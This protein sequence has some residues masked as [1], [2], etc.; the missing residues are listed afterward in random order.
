MAKNFNHRYKS[1]VN[2][3]DRKRSIVINFGSSDDLST[4]TD[5]SLAQQNLIVDKIPQVK[6]KLQTTYV[7]LTKAITEFND[8]TFPAFIEKRNTSS[9]RPEDIKKHRESLKKATKE[10][11]DSLDK[12]GSLLI[13]N[14]KLAKKINKHEQS[15]IFLA[16]FD[17][18]ILFGER[19]HTARDMIS[20]TTNRLFKKRPYDQHPSQATS[21]DDKNSLCRVTDLNATPRTEPQ[22]GHPPRTFDTTDRYFLELLG[23]DKYK[24]SAKIKSKGK[25]KQLVITFKEV[26][27]KI[28]FL[29]DLHKR[30]FEKQPSP[31]I[32][33]NN[34][35]GSK[36]TDEDGNV[37]H[38][39]SDGS[40]E[41]SSSSSIDKDHS[42]DEEENQETHQSSTRGLGR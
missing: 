25:G 28:N 42:S 10:A 31:P 5:P 27:D 40:D 15:R 35:E 33:N 39:A 1:L 23:S 16:I 17:N 37:Y 13:K 20:T 22:D 26:K 19:F 34:N 8:E 9:I 4:T 38:D 7:E 6:D 41:E 21:I 14:E 24:D 36:L 12:I 2:S 32:Q 11:K 18:P 3:V 30:T 29:T